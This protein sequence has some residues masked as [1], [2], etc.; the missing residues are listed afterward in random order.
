MQE[1]T[2]IDLV[3]PEDS[4]FVMA[5]VRDHNYVYHEKLCYKSDLRKWFFIT[6]GELPQGFIVTAWKDLPTIH[7]I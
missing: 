2:S 6:G 7:S 5:N 1:W 3:M 4:H